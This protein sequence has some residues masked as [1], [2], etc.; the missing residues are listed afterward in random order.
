[1]LKTFICVILNSQLHNWVEKKKPMRP[2]CTSAIQQVNVVLNMI[3]S[4]CLSHE[5][6]KPDTATGFFF[7]FLDDAHLLCD[8]DLTQLGGLHAF[9]NA[10]ATFARHNIR[11]FVSAIH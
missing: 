1:M 7:T 10:R 5:A 8:D 2:F 6:L 9:L 4:T 11:G 3:S